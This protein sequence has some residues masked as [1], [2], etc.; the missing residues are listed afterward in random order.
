MVP[1]AKW[2]RVGAF[3]YTTWWFGWWWLAT[4]RIDRFWLPV[5]PLLA[6]LG[7]YAQEVR[8][9]F[10]E[11]PTDRDSDSHGLESFCRAPRLVAGYTAYFV[12]MEQLRT[13]PY[14]LP[15]WVVYLNNSPD[16]RTVL[17]VGEAAVFDYQVPILYNTCFDPCW[18]E[19]LAQGRDLAEVRRALQQHGISHILV[20]WGEINRYRSPGN[21]GYCSFVDE[22]L[23]EQWERGRLLERV[24]LAWGSSVVLYR[25]R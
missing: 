20:H 18:I 13:D 2:L 4:H 24:S 1:R 6:L 23:F 12:P 8:S 9:E 14:R 21:Y 15:P 5:L 7:G 17:L 16:V 11:G 19:T 10:C 3:L 22:E 25:V